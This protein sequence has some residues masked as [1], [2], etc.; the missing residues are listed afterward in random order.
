MKSVFLVKSPLQLLNAIE[1]KHYFKVPK[2][3]C[4]LIVMADRKSQYQLLNL[5]KLKAEWGTVIV[6]NEVNL[7]FGNP[8]ETNDYGWFKRLWMGDVLKKSI[9]NVRRINRIRKYLP[10]V[11][12]IFVGYINYVY[13]VHYVNVTKHDEVL[14]LDDG[15]VT[16]EFS[17]HRKNNEARN[18]SAIKK[19]KMFL[20]RYLQGLESEVVKHVCF[21]TMYDIE[22]SGNDCV[23]KNNYSH[24]KSQ[25]SN[26]QLTGNIFFLGSPLCEVGVVSSNDYLKNLSK[27]IN[28]YGKS[29]VTYIAHRRESPERLE[30]IKQCL[31][32]RVMYLE[33][34]IESYLATTNS[35]PK[36]VSSFISSALDSCRV[37]FG[38]KL[39]VVS[40]KL[41]ITDSK[42]ID[43]IEKAYKSYE[44][45]V[46]EN[47]YI[48]YDY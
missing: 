15:N 36:I 23:V 19:L 33:L 24:I 2:K 46:N 17:R 18:L 43:K 32:I 29:N 3:D 5:V 31:D 11:K 7:F 28:Y 20:K 40:F 34:P 44:D 8:I 6:L 38:E 14:L 26:S 1:A 25:I 13:M 42:E 39:T 12:Y 16:F 10:E 4:V 47:F 27:V 48:I 45:K 9:F 41:H 22:S 37:I 30:E 21:F 35:M